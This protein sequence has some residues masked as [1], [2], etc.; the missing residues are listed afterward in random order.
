M[1][2]TEKLVYKSLPLAEEQRKILNALEN[3]GVEYIFVE[4]PPGIGKSHTISAIAFD[5]I[6]R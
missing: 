4:G 2:T 5:S 6:L 3:K 1:D